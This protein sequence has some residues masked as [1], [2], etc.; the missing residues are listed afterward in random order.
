MNFISNSSHFSS[1]I[2]SDKCFWLFCFN[3]VCSWSLKFLDNSSYCIVISISF[4]FPVCSGRVFQ[5]CSCWCNFLLIVLKVFNNFMT[6]FFIRFNGI[7]PVFSNLIL[8]CEIDASWMSWSWC[9]IVYVLNIIFES[10]FVLL[11][12]FSSFF[13]PISSFF[14]KFFSWLFS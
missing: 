12:N 3:L 1:L 9:I 13:L 6:K 7:S 10:F 8:V 5:S 14:S 11:T 4:S 2:I